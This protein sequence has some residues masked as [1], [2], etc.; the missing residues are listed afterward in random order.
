M[1]SSTSMR[2]NAS[3]VPVCDYFDSLALR[4]QLPANK[5]SFPDHTLGGVWEWDY[6]DFDSRLTTYIISMQLSA[7]HVTHSNASSVFTTK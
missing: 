4:W 7:G 6:S 1:Q 5:F 2:S 3:S